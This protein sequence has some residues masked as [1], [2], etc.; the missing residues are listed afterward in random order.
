MLDVVAGWARPPAVLV[1][2]HD[3]QLLDHLPRVMQLQ[4][5]RLEPVESFDHVGRVRR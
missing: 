1:I 5:G 2:S 3:P 4:G